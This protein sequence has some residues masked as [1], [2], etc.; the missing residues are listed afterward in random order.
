MKPPGEI[1]GSEA[2]AERVL[3]E[4]VASVTGESMAFRDTTQAMGYS[5]IVLLAVANWTKA[6]GLTQELHDY[7]RVQLQIF[8]AEDC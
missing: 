3:R 2:Q 7:M 4:A 1:E 6:R 5:A 8:R